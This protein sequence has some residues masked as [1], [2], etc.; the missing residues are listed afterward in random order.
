MWFPVQFKQLAV[1]C[2]TTLETH[3]SEARYP[4]RDLNFSEV[5]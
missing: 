3:V 2:K 4:N 5:Y 1:G